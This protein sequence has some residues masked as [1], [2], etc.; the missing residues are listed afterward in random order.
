M[1]LL[2]NVETSGYKLKSILALRTH[3]NTRVLDLTK[4]LKSKVG[5]TPACVKT[6]KGDRTPTASRQASRHE[7]KK[8]IADV[9]IMTQIGVRRFS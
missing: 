5:R 8:T 2:T 3:I 4:G 9:S 7:T 6:C 1:E